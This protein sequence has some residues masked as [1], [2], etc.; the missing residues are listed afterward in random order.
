[1][2]YA[3]DLIFNRFTVDYRAL[4]KLHI[5]IK[6][7]FYYPFYDLKLYLAHKLETNLAKMLVP[8]DMKPRLLLFK[9][10]KVY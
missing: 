10:S 9:L 4:H 3:L 6:S 7:V 1:M 5:H 2:T 8:F